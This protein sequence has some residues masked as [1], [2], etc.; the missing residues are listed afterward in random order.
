GAGVQTNTNSRWGDYSSMNVD[1]TDDCTF[2]YTQEYYATTDTT[3]TTAPFGVNWQ[4]RVAS[5][6]VNPTC[7]APAQGTLV[8]NV[9]NCATGLPVSG[10]LVSIDGNLYGATG[11]SGSNSSQLA[12][13]SYTV[14]ASATNYVAGTTSVTITDG[15]TTVVNVCVTPVP[16]I[17]TAGSTITAESCSPADN[18]MSPGETVTVDF[19][20]KNV[21]TAPTSNLV[22]TLQA[23]G[24]VTSPSGPQSYGAVP[25]DG[26]TVS[27]PFT[28]T[29]DSS[30]SCGATI[31]ATFDLQDGPN[32][33]GTVTYTFRL[34]AL[35]F[36]S[37]TA[38]YST[39]NI[40]TPIPDVSTVDI[41]ISVSDVGAV[42]DVN[43]KVRLNHTFDGDLELRLIAPDGTTVMLSDNRG[44]SGDNFGT[45]ANDCS[46]TPTVFDDSASTAIASGS[47]PFAGTFKPDQ[48]LAGLN[49][50]DINGTWK[51]RVSDTAA[52]DVGTVFCVQLE[53]S[54]R[55]YLCCPF[56][57]GTPGIVPQPPATLVSECG[58]N[59]A[60]DP[61]EVVTMSF[62]LVNNGSAPTTDLVATLQSSGGVTPHSGPQSYGSLSPIGGASV[63]R[64]FTFSVSSAVACGGNFVATFDLTDGPMFLGTASFTI[65]AGG[66]FTNVSTFSNTGAITI[67]A[68]GTGATA[69][70]PANPY[71]SNI[72]VSGIVG[73]VT[74]VRVK[75][76]G[77]N[78]T[79]PGDVD[80][81]LVGPTGQKFTIL[82]DVLGTN[83]WVNINYTLDDS[84]ATLVPS[85]GTA[86][87]GTFRPTN[88]GTG[89]LFPV[90]APLGPYQFPA[91]AGSAT[92]ASVFNGQN[93]N[94]T[95]SL[96]VV[97]DAGADAGNV[98][99]GWT[100]EITTEDP[101]CETIPVVDVTNVSVDKPSLW[102]PNHKM[103]D[104]TVN[105][106]V[107][108][109]SFC[110]L[111]VTSNEPI[112][113][114]GDDDIG[115]DWEIVDSHK[116]RLRAERAGTGTGRIYTITITCQNGVNTDVETVQVK[117]PLTKK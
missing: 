110:T 72:S 114:T 15:N 78:H 111:S 116:V 85:T 65:K 5:F 106:A 37:T 82:S 64:N 66:T 96:Y 54:R 107:A 18:A 48:P 33:L 61:G 3:P 81:L 73:T 28:F 90:P 68:V 31:T 9:T 69:G 112:T 14:T 43:V 41:P 21:G 34:G 74:N 1:P 7:V 35:G 12:P 98:S 44:G 25:N 17:Q 87:S 20:M 92:F 94:G 2:W 59:G 75:L 103:V 27:R 80:M 45:G 84:G 62:P 100:L 6:K 49:G 76:T 42:A 83:D 108:S 19:G 10:A 95:W 99:G 11:A 30:A 86:V 93:P 38:T 56:T 70:A 89:D 115:P 105:Y 117:V 29:V 8:V 91:T 24:G 79:F 51:L 55:E 97:D 36:G 60:P 16:L 63:A 57:G 26:S 113:G 50:K 40:A 101:V 22:A 77:L 13:G 67:P 46:G 32:N 104:V 47:A 58:T 71:P 52:A 4:T 23:T 102:P 39:G 88:Y 53:I 109:C